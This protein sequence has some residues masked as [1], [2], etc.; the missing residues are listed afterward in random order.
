MDNEFEIGHEIF[1]EL[2]AGRSLSVEK[3][4]TLVTGRDVA[5]SEPAAGAERRLGRQGRFAE[6]RRRAHAQLGAHLWQRLAIEC[7]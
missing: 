1:T 7:R 4:V 6:I 5:T 2:G 3:V